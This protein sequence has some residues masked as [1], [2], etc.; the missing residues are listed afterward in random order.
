[1]SSGLGPAKGFDSVKLMSNAYTGL[2]RVA[3]DD[4][5]DRGP[6]SVEPNMVRA[7]EDGFAN[8]GGGSSVGSTGGAGSSSLLAEG[9]GGGVGGVAIFL[10]YFRA[11]LTAEDL[12]VDGSMASVLGFFRQLSSEPSAADFCFS[13]GAPLSLSLFS[14]DTEV[15]IDFGLSMLP[16][17]FSFLFRAAAKAANF[18]TFGAASPGAPPRSPPRGCRGSIRISPRRC[19]GTLS[20]GQFRKKAL[21]ENCSEQLVT[22]CVYL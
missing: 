7:N 20:Q 5:L 3:K 19:N 8:T 10:G 1:M 17:S 4:A 16:W 18:E 13:E 11:S 12:L 2:N 22:G 9:S 14:R 6:A 21:A 15:L